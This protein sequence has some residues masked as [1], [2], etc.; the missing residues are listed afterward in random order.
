MKKILAGFFIIVAML[1][2]VSIVLHE[3]LVYHPAARVSVCYSTLQHTGDPADHPQQYVTPQ[4]LQACPEKV[5]KAFECLAKDA[6]FIA[7]RGVLDQWL[8]L[9]SS[10]CLLVAGFLLLLATAK[11]GP[12][13]GK[14]VSLQPEFRS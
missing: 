11:P 13:A 2:G 8:P 7:D 12:P 4:D 6:H 1:N 10:F 5:Q 9:F 14:P 3:L